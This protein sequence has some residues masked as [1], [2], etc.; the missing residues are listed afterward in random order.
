[1]EGPE[2]K[3]ISINCKS[4]MQWQ[5]KKMLASIEGPLGNSVALE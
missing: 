2:N 4:Q 5:H 3:I 1:M